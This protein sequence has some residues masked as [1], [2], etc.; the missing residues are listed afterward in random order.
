MTATAPAQFRDYLNLSSWSST[1]D[2]KQLPDK[3]YLG[4]RCNENDRDLG[5]G[6]ILDI[7]QVV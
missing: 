3:V 6:P 1:L 2:I 7:R 4:D 5:Y